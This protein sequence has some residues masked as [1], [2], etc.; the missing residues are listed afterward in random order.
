MASFSNLRGSEALAFFSFGINKDRMFA[1]THQDY[2]NRW[3]QPS[4]ED[5]EN[6]SKR[7]FL[8]EGADEE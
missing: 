8:Q 5:W 4:V 6:A 3:F 7:Y 1:I 2:F